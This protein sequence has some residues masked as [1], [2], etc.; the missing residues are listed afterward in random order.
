MTTYNKTK[1]IL[2]KPWVFWGLIILLFLGMF[3]MVNRTSAS[4]NVTTPS[5]STNIVEQSFQDKK[6]VI[7]PDNLTRM[8]FDKKSPTEENN[9]RSSNFFS[10]NSTMLLLLFYTIIISLLFIYREK[11]HKNKLVLMEKV[12]DE[13]QIQLAKKND[14]ANLYEGI[15]SEIKKHR[16]ILEPEL[17]INGLEE[18]LNSDANYVII[19]ARIVVEKIIL[20]LYSQYFEDEATLNGMM[21]ALYRK[22]ILNPSMNNYA[23]TIKAFGNRAIHPNLDTPVVFKS[24]EAVLVIG[25]LLQFINEL[26]SNNLLK[27]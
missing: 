15:D 7:D 17:K 14:H 19:S 25:S 11:Q 26:D 22:R 18:R 9:N 3:F 21:A 8:D 23:H 1:Y 16:T 12:E 2:T 4:V 27:D 6:I 24:K 5:S 10:T 20:K 13:L